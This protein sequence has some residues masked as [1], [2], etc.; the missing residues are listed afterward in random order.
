MLQNNINRN[1]NKNKNQKIL[2]GN[3]IISKLYLQIKRV[4]NRKKL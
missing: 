2:T 4:K 3:K 1:I